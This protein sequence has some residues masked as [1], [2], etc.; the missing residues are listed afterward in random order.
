MV[1]AA[2]TAARAAVMNGRETTIMFLIY[3]KM[4]VLKIFLPNR[5]FIKYSSFECKIF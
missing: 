2:M 3:K 1:A 5:G 4:L